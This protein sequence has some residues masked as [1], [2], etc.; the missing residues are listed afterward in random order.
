VR[1]ALFLTLVVA[2]AGCV[3]PTEPAKQA[4]EIASVAAEGALLAH[5]AAE[6]DTTAT[7]TS[8]HAKALREKLA[9]LEP[10]LRDRRLREL[11]GSVS[12]ELER[13]SAHPG[14]RAGASAIERRLDED[15]TAAEELA[16]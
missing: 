10:K 3:V 12:T 7:F 13:L 2:L 14:D 4:E 5:D 15:A 16:S 8:V 9:M 6:G 11:A 1:A